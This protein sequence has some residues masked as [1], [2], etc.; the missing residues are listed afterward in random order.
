MMYDSILTHRA[1][2]KSSK[3]GRDCA[4]NEVVSGFPTDQSVTES[5]E[6][7]IPSEVWGEAAAENKFGAFSLSQKTSGQVLVER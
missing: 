7:K 6:R 1:S 2:R 3:E 5:R 4:S